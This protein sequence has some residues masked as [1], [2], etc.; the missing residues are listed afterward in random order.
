MKPI[1][2]YYPKCST[3]IKAKKYLESLGIVFEARDI[4]VQTPT[5][6]ELTT[7]LERSGLPLSKFYNTSGKLY[8]ELQMKEKRSTM[9]EDKQLQLLSENGMLIKRPIFITDTQVLV[10]F[11]ESEYLKLK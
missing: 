5:K 7:Y 8:K 6:E 11:K 10:G 4:T 3:C 1:F 9:S 2:I